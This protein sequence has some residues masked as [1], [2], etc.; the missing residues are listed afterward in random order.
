MNILPLVIQ[1][2]ALVCLIA[3]ALGLWPS[4]VQWGWAGMALWLFS[5]M[6]SGV[7]LHQ[8]T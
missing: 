1:I 6:I 2:I 3:G 7:V 5:L 8:A 4:K